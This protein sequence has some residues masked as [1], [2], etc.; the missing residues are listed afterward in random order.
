MIRISVGVRFVPGFRFV[1]DLR[2]CESEFRFVRDLRLYFMEKESA[3]DARACIENL[4]PIFAHP[5]RFRNHEPEHGANPARSSVV[6]LN[7][8]AE[9]VL[10]APPAFQARIGHR[11]RVWEAET[12]TLSSRTV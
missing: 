1:R 8:C 12:V 9:Q 4:L 5:D 2:L 10:R 3:S 6:Q 7:P 11:T